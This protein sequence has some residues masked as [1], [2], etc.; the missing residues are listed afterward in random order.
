VLR[1]AKMRKTRMQR[2]RWEGRTLI[3]A[4]QGC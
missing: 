4:I 3:N 1:K 2:Q